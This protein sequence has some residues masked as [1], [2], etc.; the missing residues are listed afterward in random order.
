[1][2]QE[3][4]PAGRRPDPR[5]HLWP[6]AFARFTVIASHGQRLFFERGRPPV[7]VLRARLAAR[8]LDEIS[9]VIRLCGKGASASAE[10]S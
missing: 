9:A 5:Q 4:I 10:E 6:R 7:K 1:M 3:R 8:R 2:V